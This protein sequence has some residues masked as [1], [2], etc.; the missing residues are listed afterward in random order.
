VG[1]VC[2]CCCALLS[3]QAA[4]PAAQH[5]VAT[6]FVMV[7][8]LTVLGKLT[9]QILTPALHAELARDADESNSSAPKRAE[10][11]TRSGPR[12][13]ASVSARTLDGALRPSHAPEG[14]EEAES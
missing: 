13:G 7:E 12:A 8:F 3:A 5:V 2:V 1:V 10:G 9:A 14:P 4:L 11:A 6:R